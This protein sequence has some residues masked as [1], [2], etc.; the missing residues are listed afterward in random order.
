MSNIFQK[1]L[2]KLG[3]IKKEKISNYQ[4]IYADNQNNSSNYHNYNNQISNPE[5]N[6]QNTNNKI[7]VNQLEMENLHNTNEIKNKENLKIYD[8][9]KIDSKKINTIWDIIKARENTQAEHIINCL[10]DDEWIDME[11]LKNRIK[12]QYNIEYQN[13]KSLYPYIKTLTDINLIKLNNTGKKRT[14]KKNVII[15]EK[16]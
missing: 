9:S 4:N 14:W 7:N 8:I 5:N 2:I 11:D 10:P 15:I 1:L 6:I 13:E 3:L 12:L 16:E